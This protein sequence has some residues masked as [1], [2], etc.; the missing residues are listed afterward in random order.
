MN[1]RLLMLILSFTVALIFSIM[2]LPQELFYLR[3]DYM[4]G[5]ILIWTLFDSERVS[6]G[7]GFTVGLCQDVLSGALLGAHGFALSLVCYFVLKF[8]RRLR[9]I[10]VWQQALVLFTL[11]LMNQLLLASFEAFSGHFSSFFNPL[12]PAVSSAGLWLLAFFIVH[13]VSK[14]QSLL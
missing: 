3:P 14:E 2:P 13:S 9:F 6:I 10:S 11:V 12:L 7:L 5:L 4:V 8:S 1:E